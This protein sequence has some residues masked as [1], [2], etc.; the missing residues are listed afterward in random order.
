MLEALIWDVDGT[1]AETERDG[2]RVAFNQAFD[3]LGLSWRWDVQRYGELLHITGGRERLLHD[4]AL[5]PDAPTR[6]DDR[7]A[8][9]RE[10]HRLKNGF[11]ARLVEAGAI[12][13]RPGVR[14]LIDAC[15]EAGIALAVATTT[16]RSNVQVLFDVL[17]G[18]TW[19]ARFAAVVCAEQAPSKKPDPQAYTLALCL[20]GLAPEQALAIEDSPNGLQ[21]ARAAGL[22]CGITRSAYFAAD[23]FDGA[24]WIRD[25]LETPEP[26]TLPLLRQSFPVNIRAD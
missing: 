22:A 4:M 21:A 18:S 24:A 3:A 23:R 9:A 25:D 7:E 6:P 13:A 8:L 19:P 16:S 17:F 1:I 20:L 15:G 5:R 2:H 11:Y 10:L 26:M 12:A 14:R